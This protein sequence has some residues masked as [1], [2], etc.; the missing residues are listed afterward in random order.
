MLQIPESTSSFTRI[1][2]IN[3]IKKKKKKK[4]GKKL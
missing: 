1:K 4:K 2:T 3:E